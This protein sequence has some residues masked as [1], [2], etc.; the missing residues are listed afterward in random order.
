[1]NSHE[2]IKLGGIWAFVGGTTLASLTLMVQL[3]SYTLASVYTLILIG[4]WIYKKFKGKQNV[5]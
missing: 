1:M 4:D 2:A 5:S 3:T